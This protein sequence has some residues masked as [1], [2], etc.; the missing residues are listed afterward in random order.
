M[1]LMSL[2]KSR[3]IAE[4][5]PLNPQGPADFI[6][7]HWMFGSPLAGGFDLVTCSASQPLLQ[8]YQN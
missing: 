3:H 1:S 7:P 2:K 4:W 5:E 8:H 6:D